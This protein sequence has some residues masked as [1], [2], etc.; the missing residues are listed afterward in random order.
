MQSFASI[1]ENIPHL[2]YSRGQSFIGQ[3][4]CYYL[5]WGVIG[6]GSV[7]TRRF[8]STIC[9]DRKVDF[10]I[11]PLAVVHMSKVEW[12]SCK[13]L[14]IHWYV[15]VDTDSLSLACSGWPCSGR[16]CNY[17]CTR[18]GEKRINLDTASPLFPKRNIYTAYSGDV[19]CSGLFSLYL[20][21]SEFPSEI[22]QN[23]TWIF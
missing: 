23:E 12:R 19:V 15:V 22:I 6:A 21:P 20:W 13:A 5:W 8:V 1:C 9:E 18:C 11:V 14:W 2:E 4:T 17:R 10:L 7:G 3:N 16:P